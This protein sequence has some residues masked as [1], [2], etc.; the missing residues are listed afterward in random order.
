MFS[1]CGQIKRGRHT[2]KSQE[3]TVLSACA[4]AELNRAVWKLN[5]AMRRSKSTF[6][7]PGQSRTMFDPGRLNHCH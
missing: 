1:E 4:A 6:Q 7:E 3:L 5:Q 2:A